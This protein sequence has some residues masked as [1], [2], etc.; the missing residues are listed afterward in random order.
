MTDVLKCL[1]VCLCLCTRWQA[2]GP[3]RR[4]RWTLRRACGQPGRIGLSALRLAA[5]ASHRG[6]GSV[7][8]LHLPKP[9]PCPTLHQTGQVTCRGASEVPSSHLC[10][11]TTLRT[12]LGSTLRIAH[13]LFPLIT[14]PDCLCTGMP[15]P[16]VEELLYR[17]RPIHPHPFSSQNS[18]Q[19]VRAIY[20]FTDL[21]ST[22]LHA[23]TTSKHGP[24]GGQPVL[25]RRGLEEV[26]AEGRSRPVG[27]A[28][29][30]EG[31]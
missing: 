10:V 20:P 18:P 29:L 31:E 22:L 30:Q 24:S 17:H 11:L 2:D 12:T 6:A 28:H 16:G 26:A 9:L 23:P 27:R 3:G 19:A 1:F 4:L 13:L 25:E 7:Y 21:H 5:W 14:T 8:L 15:T